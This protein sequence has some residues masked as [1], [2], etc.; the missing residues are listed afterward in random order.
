MEEFDLQSILEKYSTNKLVLIIVSA[1]AGALLTKFLPFCWENLRRAMLFLFKR[2][3]GSFLFRNFEKQYLDWVVTELRQLRLAGIVSHDDT[4][5]PQ[6]EQVFVSLSVRK[7]KDHIQ[8]QDV[9]DVLERIIRGY[10]AVPSVREL[11]DNLYQQF[12]SFR[13]SLIEEVKEFFWTLSVP[14]LYELTW[15]SGTKCI[16]IPPL[17]RLQIKK[18][19][20]FLMRMLNWIKEKEI[21][22]DLEELMRSWHAIQ[23]QL[24]TRDESEHLRRVLFKNRHLAL[25][26]GPGSGK[27]TLLQYI[28][29]T[30]ARERAGDKSLRLK[31]IIK[32]RLKTN[33]WLFPI[34]VPLRTIEGLLKER[35]STDRSVSILELLPRLLPADLVRDIGADQALRN[36][37]KYLKKG[38]CIVLLDGLDE[39]PTEAAFFNVVKAVESLVASY[40]KNRFIVTSRIAGWRSGV[41]GDFSVF[42]VNELN[43]HQINN[44]IDSWYLAVERNASP[45]PH[46]GAAEIKSFERNAALKASNLRQIL[47]ENVSLMRL[48]NNPMLLSIIALVHRSLATLPRERAK[49]YGECSKILLE[50]WDIS[51]GVHVD[52]TNLKLEQKEMILRRIAMAMHTGEIGLKGGGREAKKGE[53]VAIIENLLPT[54]GRSEEDAER[55]LH[56]LIERSGIMIERQRDILSFSH[57]TFQEY[58]SARYLEYGEHEKHHMFLLNQ[59]QLL[60]DWWREVILLYAG[61]LSDASSFLEKI[62]A[63][64]D[65]LCCQRLRLAVL[66]LGETVAVKRKE[67]RQLIA[68]AAFRIRNMGIEYQKGDAIPTQAVDYLTAW[69]KDE[70][71]YASAA[72]MK[73]NETEMNSTHWQVSLALKINEALCDSRRGV[74]LAA[75]KC[76]SEVAK[77]TMPRIL[78]DQIISMV[79]DKDDDV[80]YSAIKCLGYL[81]PDRIELDLEKALTKAMSSTDPTTAI[82]AL[83]S[84]KR[85]GYALGSRESVALNVARKLDDNDPKVRMVAAETLLNFESKAAKGQF[86][87]YFDKLAGGTFSMT[88]EDRVASKYLF[89]LVK[90]KDIADK[91]STFAHSKDPRARCIAAE[92]IGTLSS[93]DVKASSFGSQFF[94]LI[95]DDAEDVR[96]TAVQ[97]FAALS[98]SGL[99][100]HFVQQLCDLLYNANSKSWIRAARVVTNLSGLNLSER[101]F[102]KLLDLLK[103]QGNFKQLK[104]QEAISGQCV[105]RWVHDYLKRAFFANDRCMIVAALA[106]ARTPESKQ[107]VIPVLLEVFNRD[108]TIVRTEALWALSKIGFESSQELLGI[109]RT[110]IYGKKTAFRRPVF[111]IIARLALE[112]LNNSSREELILGLLHTLKRRESALKTIFRDLQFFYYHIRKMLPHVVS[113]D[114]RVEDTTQLSRSFYDGEKSL[115]CAI[116]HLCSDVPSDVIDY[117]F[118]IV[119]S[120]K[121]DMLVRL[122]ALNTLENLGSNL[123]SSEIL[124][125][126]SRMFKENP[127]LIKLPLFFGYRVPLEL[128]FCLPIRHPW[129]YELV[130]G[131]AEV[132][133]NSFTAHSCF[134]LL[135]KTPKEDIG[136]MLSEAV[137]EENPFAKALLLRVIALL[138]EISADERLIDEVIS[139]SEGGNTLIRLSAIQA[140]RHFPHSQKKVLNAIMKRLSDDESEIRELAW[141][142]YVYGDEILKKERPKTTIE[143]T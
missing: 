36:F 23:K 80:A 104:I 95:I 101:L 28:G 121:F 19:P 30:Y 81:P 86:L 44:F 111:D 6:L 75:L 128:L 54:L 115:F 114:R 25:L 73:L 16:G 143:R 69:A 89:G 65:D 41:S 2:V 84:F 110:A 38:K 22:E 79:D 105:T 33:K 93:E 12:G 9:I 62:P 45:S 1:A 102:D 50:Q 124:Y 17:G 100:T 10:G 74:R 58:F 60:S 94:S 118:K 57:H 48:A 3:G 106:S 70:Q 47:R 97:S 35:S 34:F 13:P 107:K 123:K 108:R 122:N 72:T 134:I 135:C 125:K 90:H 43:D 31:G 26:G 5:R 141:E 142:T 11:I 103:I 92:F 39:V 46:L 82:C 21:R 116:E 137:Q 66:C 99:E 136:K 53:L 18:M 56:R 51:R 85:L 8:T 113:T 52:D 130:T 132:L 29:L 129:I 49:L 96:R 67:I 131:R 64:E 78:A 109:F 76:V 91:M 140:M 133:A 88:Y 126:L 61:L 63:P 112:K 138:P 120:K 42:Y 37:H 68:A 55:L 119:G 7:E 4:R 117:L 98:R 139:A 77:E 127:K 87:E 24:I 83:E 15:L 20:T 14:R 32:K 40:K 71:W 59:H 27:T